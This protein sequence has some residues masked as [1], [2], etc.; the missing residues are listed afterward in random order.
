MKDHK[1]MR[2]QDMVILLAIVALNRQDWQRKGLKLIHRSPFPQNKT[3][4]ELLTISSAEI[5]GSLHRSSFAGLIDFDT[6]K[7]FMQ[8]LFEFIQFGVKY[9]FP[10][11]PGPLVRGIPTGHSA[12]PL[13]SQLTFQ[14]EMVWEHP[15]GTVRGQSIVPLYSTVPSIVKNNSL[16]YELL[17]LTDSLRIGG[18]REKE[19]AISELQKRFFQ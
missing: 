15:E 2:P 14:E 17:A 11:Q 4:A 1:G 5:S 9:V 6:K 8:A 16:L 10:V 12:E 3:L 13:R 7:V 19:L 18:A